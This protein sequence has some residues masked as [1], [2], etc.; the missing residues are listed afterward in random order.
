MAARSS[1]MNHHIDKCQRHKIAIDPHHCVMTVLA[2]AK[3]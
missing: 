1:V 3:I 2:I